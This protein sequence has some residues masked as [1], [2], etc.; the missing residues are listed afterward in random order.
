MACCGRKAGARLEYEVKTN[1]GQ[2]FRVGS[3]A[4]AKIKIAT[5][6]GGTYRAVSKAA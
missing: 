3:I 5:L 2:T 6:G 1:D 4:E